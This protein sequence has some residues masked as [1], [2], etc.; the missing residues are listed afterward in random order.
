MA[1][2]DPRRTG[3][4]RS[5]RRIRDQDR[6]G[7]RRYSLT[8]GLRVRLSGVA[9][10][11]EDL[12]VA[13]S[14][15]DSLLRPAPPAGGGTAPDHVDL[16][17]RGGLLLDE[18]RRLTVEGFESVALPRSFV[19]GSEVVVS[20][21]DVS[22]D[23]ARGLILGEARVELPEGL[24]QL[25]PEE[26]VL[27]D[28]IIGPA[29]VSGRLEAQYT[30]E[31]NA[32]TK[33]FVGR[34]SGEL[35]GVPFAF[36]TLAI[37]LQEN[38]LV[39][40]SL[41]GQLLL[42]FFDH[43]VG[44]SVALRSDGSFSVDVGAGITL[45]TV[46]R[47][48]LLR[49]TVEHI[50]FEVIDGR[51]LVHTGGTV[52]LLIGHEEWPTFRA[53]DIS[54]DADG[55]IAVH[56][57]GLSLQGG[58]PLDLGALPAGA[59]RVPGVT[60][61]KLDLSGNPLNE[62]LIADVELSTV[63][64]LGPFTATLEQIGVHARLA[65]RLSGFGADVSDLSFRPPTRIAIIVDG[66]QVSG[67]GFISRDAQKGEYSGMLELQI[68]EK[69]AVK[70]IGLLTTK[71]PD[72]GKGFSFVVLIFVEGF[73][74]IQLGYGFVLTG[75]G[76]LLAI[77]RTFDEEALRA[78]LKNH[79]LD[80]VMFPQDPIRNA[81]EIISNLSKVFPPANGHYLFGPMVQIA[82]TTRLPDGSKGYS[83]VLIIFVEGFAPI[84]LGYGFALTGIGGLLA[85]NR[86]FD[87][88][89]LRAGLKNHTLD[90]VLFPQDPIRN[91]PQIVSNLN[92]RLPTGQWPSSVRAD[93][94]N[95]LAHAGA[96]HGGSGCRAG[97]RHAAAAADSGPGR[98]DSAQTRER[99]GALADGRRRRARFRSGHRF[100]GCVAL[101]F[102]AT[103]EVRADGRHGD[104]TEVG[105]FA[106][107]CAGCRR[108]ASCL[109]PAN[110][111]SQAGTYRLQSLHGRQPAHSLRSLLR[112]DGQHGAIRRARRALRRRIRLQYSGRNRLRR[113]DPVRPVLFPR[114][115]LRAVAAQ[116]QFDQS[117]QS[118]SRGRA[119]RPAPAAPQRQGDL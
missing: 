105:G 64:K 62:G 89:A 96:D 22:I 35:G 33:R 107:L 10:A 2:V 9:L 71:M 109:Q 15:P 93:G 94:A 6:R 38:D 8:L 95:R 1:V 87:E 36:T 48:G 3:R 12:A 45:A 11:V 40:A 43:P 53:D 73:A 25:A 34:G 32:E 18:D 99:S 72:G 23:T 7:R 55:D 63:A 28:A 19:G 20:A 26:L 49:L 14:I 85:I 106:E 86:T 108:L 57:A 56:G 78:G 54:I 60:I 74:P 111:L 31:F 77:N 81:P 29:G 37:E 17:L 27:E 58:K 100:A 102:A 88:E 83:L 119:G 66:E 97:V 68:A 115:F 44:V 117:V 118:P 52:T 24:P 21:T 80:S 114:R 65:V 79:A 39:E 69:I 98:G 5:A 51:L 67:G 46:E 92:K 76:G 103:E 116:T 47:E 41:A 110:Q 101:R 4:V 30:P 112:A 16:V 59:G 82:W 42:P 113:V 61:D 104:A 90:S 70:G 91:A 13:L 50:G 84:Q 75:I